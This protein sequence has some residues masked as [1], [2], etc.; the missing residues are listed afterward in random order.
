MTI[1]SAAATMHLLDQVMTIASDLLGPLEAEQDELFKFPQG[2]FG[3]PDCSSFVLLGAER[4]GLYWLQSAEFSSL[5]FLLVDPFPFFPGY[6]VD[7]TDADMA[8]LGVQGPDEVSILAI[9]TLPGSIEDSPTAN[10]QGPLALNM[11]TRTA[12]QIVLEADEVGTRC[13]FRLEPAAR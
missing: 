4:E 2:L 9:V 12:R 10:L 11:R 13:D 3:F 5:A 1:S 8:D 6:A 7:L